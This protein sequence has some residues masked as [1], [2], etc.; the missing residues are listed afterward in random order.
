MGAYTL[1]AMAGAELF[2]ELD[3]NRQQFVDQLAVK[4][5]QLKDLIEQ[6]QKEND[7]LRALNEQLRGENA[8]IE[9]RPISTRTQATGGT[10]AW[11]GGRPRP[12]VVPLHEV[13]EGDPRRK[14]KQS[15]IIR[16]HDAPVHSVNFSRIGPGQVVPG[17]GATS[18]ILASASWDATI[19]LYN[20]DRDDKAA[21]FRTIGGDEETM[22]NNLV[23]MGGLYDVQFARTCP[24]VLAAAS[25]DNYVYLWNYVKNQLLTRLHGHT[26][27]VNGVTFHPSQQVI[28]TTSDDTTAIIWDFH[29]GIKL[30]TLEGHM[31][32]AYGSTFL[33]AENQYCVATCSFDQKVR[34]YDMRDKSIVE[35]LQEHFDEVIGIDYNENKRWLASGADDGYVCVWDSRAWTKPL[36]KI[37]TRESPGVQDNEVKRVA[38][39]PDGTKLATGSSSHQVLVYSLAGE[40]PSV[41]GVLA[42]LA[43]HTD[44]IFDVCFGVDDRGNE[45]LVDASHDQTC[46]VWFPMR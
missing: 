24:S 42:G 32:A 15:K 12:D 46:Y 19:S 7:A 36:F 17:E 25:A 6:L 33:G 13:P 9:G 8:Q 21:L 39:N 38:F 1:G 14:Y 29:E 35:T 11:P 16:T 30:R 44:T 45:F 18:G 10:P 34:I 2:T 37:N 4:Q 26:D 40:S 27:E 3:G 43:P 31:K 41:Y 5:N 23:R 22:D 20:L 28:C